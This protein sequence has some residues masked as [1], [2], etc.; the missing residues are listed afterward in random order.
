MNHTFSE[1]GQETHLVACVYFLTSVNNKLS[2]IKAIK[3]LQTFVGNEE[4]DFL[5]LNGV[6]CPTAQITR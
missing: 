1:R 5:I 3:R 2:T 6:A 4:F